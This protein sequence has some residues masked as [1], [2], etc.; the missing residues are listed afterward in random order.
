MND[1]WAALPIKCFIQPIN[2]IFWRHGSINACVTSIADATKEKIDDTTKVLLILK[3][4]DTAFL[5]WLHPRAM[6]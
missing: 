6:Q 5:S 1:L 2:H 3:T 4:R